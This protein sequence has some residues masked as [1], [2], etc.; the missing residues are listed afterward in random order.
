MV[1][2]SDYLLD[3]ALVQRV[4]DSSRRH[5]L[6][7]DGEA[8]A[9]MMVS[10]GSD[11]TAL[12]RIVAGCYRELGITWM[13]IVHVNHQLRGSD[14]DEDENFVR[15]LAAE[16]G[17]AVSVYVEDIQALVDETHGNMEDI[18][19]HVRYARAAENLDELCR[20]HGVD[21]AHGRILIA[22]TRDDRA[23]NF[24]MRAIVGAGLGALSSMGHRN[25][26]VVRPLLDTTRAE[27]RAWLEER[28]GSGQPPV[29]WREDTT[30]AD[31]EHFRSYVR[32]EIVPRAER[33]NPRF[34]AT[35]ARNLDILSDEN[36]LIEQ[37]ANAAAADVVTTLDDGTISIDMDGLAGVPVPLQRRIARKAILV[38]LP[39]GTRLDGFHVE[40][41]ITDGFRPGFKSLLPGGLIAYNE[42]GT[43]RFAHIDA[44]SATNAGA[45]TDPEER[46]NIALEGWLPIPGSLELGDGRVLSAELVEAGS[47]DLS[48]VREAGPDEAYLDLGL[49]PNLYVRDIE[50]GMR[51]QPL[52]MGGHSRKVSDI[53]IDRKVPSRLRNQIPV[54]MTGSSEDEDIVWLSGIMVDERY[55]VKPQTR[56]IVHLFLTMS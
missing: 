5:G 10:G 46:G 14:S 47:I 43:M 20:V 33:C 18:A 41:M 23:E 36:D 27:L 45:A 19:R 28:R 37:L 30:N 22:H 9:V 25:G 51:M 11:S 49:I 1:S 15:D 48:A 21:P 29:L 35:L 13:R 54:V 56:D 42:Y 8:A 32:H 16:L 2:D 55:K 26:R 6:F 53:L 34:K 17:I 39:S 44:R 40:D 38:Q 7:P 4:C 50:R 12:A 3:D 31:I 24:F 52:G